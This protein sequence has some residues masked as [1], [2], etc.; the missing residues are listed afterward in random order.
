MKIKKLVLTGLFCLTLATA[1]FADGETEG[2]NRA[3]SQP[4]PPSIVQI[5]VNFFTGG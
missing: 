4:E 3:A 2:G 1:V 5:I